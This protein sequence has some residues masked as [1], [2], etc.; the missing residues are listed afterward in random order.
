MLFTCIQ[1]GIAQNQI[2]P[3]VVLIIYH[4]NSHLYGELI[5]IHFVIMLRQSR[6]VYSSSL[7]HNF[8]KNKME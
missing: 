6:W 7:L 1:W 3:S 5:K 4:I 2:T 8:A